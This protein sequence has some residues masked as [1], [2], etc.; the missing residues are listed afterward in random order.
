MGVP[1]GVVQI[2]QLPASCCLVAWEMILFR[3]S[4]VIHHHHKRLRRCG[5]WK[6]LEEACFSSSQLRTML[7]SDSDHRMSKP[8]STSRA[9]SY[10][11]C[12]VRPKPRSKAKLFVCACLAVC[13]LAL[14]LLKVGG[15]RETLKVVLMVHSTRCC[16]HHRAVKFCPPRVCVCVC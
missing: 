16:R 10:L 11:N 15:T 2:A 6:P 7:V 14:L 8:S 1:K 9:E 4:L 5:A 13:A 12:S 3:S